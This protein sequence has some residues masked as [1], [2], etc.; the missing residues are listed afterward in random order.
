MARVLASL[1][2]AALLAVGVSAHGDH[3]DHSHGGEAESPALNILS[4]ADFESRVGAGGTW[5]I[6]FY[7]PWCGHCKRLAPTW[8]ELATTLAAEG[9]DAHIAKI[10]CTVHRETCTKMEVKGYPTL[11]GFKDGAVSA[12][13]SIKYPGGRDLASLKSWVTENTPAKADL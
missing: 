7:A 6:K 13:A 12:S 11:L 3:G 4:D 9:S 1:A 10:D 8:N 5:L 2:A